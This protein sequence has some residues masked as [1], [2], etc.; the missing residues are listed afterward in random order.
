MKADSAE[1]KHLMITPPSFVSYS[2]NKNGTK[3]KCV[4]SHTIQFKVLGQK[5]SIT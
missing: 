2:I 1:A 3:V 4:I 5:L